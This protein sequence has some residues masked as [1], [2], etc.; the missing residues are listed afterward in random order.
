MNKRLLATL[1]AFPLVISS[2]HA[3]EAGNGPGIKVSG[4]GTGALTMS[5]T[6]DAEFG[7]ANQA[8]GVKKDARTGVDS[9]LGLQADV[10]INNWLS[11]TGQGLVRKDAED[12]FGA[13]ATLAFAKA[14]VNDELSIRVGRV[15]A[16]V[17]MISEY[18]NVGY[19]NTF[20]RPPQE[21]YSQVPFN[22]IDGIDATWQHAFGATSVTAQLAVGSTKAPIAGNLEVKM[23][24]LVALNLVAEYGPFT[25]RFGRAD[26]KLTVK[27]STSLDG[28]LASLRAAGTGYR[29]PALNT[30]ADNLV[31]DSKKSS[32]TSLG[33]GL[34]WNNIIGQSE[35]AKRKSDSYINDTTSW[36]VMGGYRIGKFLPYYSHAKLSVD[37]VV[38]N[39][40]PTACPA[41]YPAACTPTLRALSAGV[42]TLRGSGLGQGEQST[43][44]IGLR[45]DLYSSADLKFQIDRITPKNG[46][47]LFLNA[48][49][50]FSHAVTVGTVAVDF[51]F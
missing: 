40:V 48:T 14:K 20:V 45:W 46:K 26:G 30:L 12:D 35:Y 16:P 47:G 28:L 29:M 23:K 9:N 31:A 1:L 2:A 18:R 34:D 33:L 42:A 11:L 37:S 5:N 39:T 10:T 8:R 44:S 36:Y 3:Q 27:G 13:E 41:G 50:G 49:P 19:A 25:A 51:V 6:D 15:G 32:F 21:M 17:F 22:S 7:R 43:D 4:F 38:A 24:S